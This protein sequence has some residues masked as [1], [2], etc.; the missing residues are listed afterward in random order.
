MATVLEKLIRWIDV[1]D[2]LILI[3]ELLV[4]QAQ[5]FALLCCCNVFAKD[6]ASE[7]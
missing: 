4:N 7:G 3:E 5:G 1:R 2:S 6:K